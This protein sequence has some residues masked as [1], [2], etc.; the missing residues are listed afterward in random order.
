NPVA[1]PSAA[2]A[3][4]LSFMP[5]VEAGATVGA[6]A[7]S[8]APRGVDCAATETVHAAGPPPASETA[9]C[10]VVD[11]PRRT[12]PKERP[13]GLVKTSG[14]SAWTRSIRPPPS[15]VDGTSVVPE[16]CTASPVDSSADLICAT[17]QP[18]WRCLSTAAAPATCGDAMLVPLQSCADHWFPGSDDR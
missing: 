1:S 9:S 4:T 11:V 16:E 3:P 10:L 17:V 14:L 15:R 2:P 13:L 6:A 8:V 18:G 7:V 5:T 12:S